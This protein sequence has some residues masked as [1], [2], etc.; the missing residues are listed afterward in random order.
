MK[1][2]GARACKVGLLGLTEEASTESRLQSAQAGTVH[3]L[4]EPLSF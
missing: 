1:N 3:Y 4:P 2:V